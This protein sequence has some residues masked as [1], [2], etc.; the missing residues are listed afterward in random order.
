MS[1]FYALLRLRHIE[2]APDGLTYLSRITVAGQIEDASH[3]AFADGPGPEVAV[4]VVGDRIAR[5]RIEY[6]PVPVLGIDTPA[7]KGAERTLRLC[8]ASHHDGQA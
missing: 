7:A 8:L 6:G 5:A 1:P 4:E 2:Q 3:D